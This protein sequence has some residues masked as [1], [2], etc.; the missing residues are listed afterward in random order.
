MHIITFAIIRVSV[1]LQDYKT[2]YATM[3]R[4]ADSEPRALDTWAIGIS[5][6]DSGTFSSPPSPVLARPGFFHPFNNACT[7]LCVQHDV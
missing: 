7:Q 1:H 5:A 6:G 2:L 4:I 3:K